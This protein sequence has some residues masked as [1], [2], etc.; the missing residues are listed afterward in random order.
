MIGRKV[1]AGIHNVIQMRYCCCIHLPFDLSLVFSLAAL[2]LWILQTVVDEWLDSYKRSQKAGLLVLINFIVRS[3]GCKGQRS[4]ESP[5]D[6]GWGSKLKRLSFQ[7]QLRQWS[8][9][10][11]WSPSMVTMPCPGSV[12]C[13]LT[14]HH[15]DILWEW[16]EKNRTCILIFKVK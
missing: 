3:C 5:P 8:T 13:L 1:W 11:Y 9:V 6:E 10:N 16:N 15:I 7:F 4:R 2:S 14:T 12:L